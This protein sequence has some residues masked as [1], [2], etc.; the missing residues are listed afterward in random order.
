MTAPYARALPVAVVLVAALV[1]AWHDRGSIAAADFLPLELVVFL[2]LAVTLW[3]GV[4]VRPTGAAAAALGLFALLA[5]WAGASAL[6]APVPSLARDE[7]L[8]VLFGAAALA[9]PVLTLRTAADRLAALAVFVAGLVIVAGATALTLSGSSD[10][11]DVFRYRR[12]SFPIT[13]ANASAGLFLAGFWPA[14]MLAG[15]RSGRP[16]VRIA[17]FAAA[18]LLL[19]SSLLAQSK[20]GVVGLVAST[21]VLAA[22]SQARLR[23]LATALLAAVPAAL[24]FGPLTAA[25]T[26]T[27]DTELHDVHRAAGALLLVTVGSALLGAALAAADRRIDLSA[28]R[29][30]IGRV[31]LGAFAVTL[32]AALAVIALSHPTTWVSDHWR[33]FKKAPSPAAVSGTTHL[34]ELGSNRYDFWRVALGEFERHP[35]VGDGARGFGPAYLV[36]GRSSET[37]ARAHSLPLELLGEEGVVGFALAFAGYAV[38]LGGLAVRTRRRSAA[39]TAALGGCALLLAQACVDWTFTFPALT[40]PFFLLAG[41]GLAD[42]G[43]AV[44]APRARRAGWI[45]ALVLAA[46]LVA[47]PWL[48]AKLVQR[49]LTTRSAADLRWAHRLDPIS[50]DPWIAE[51]Q[52]ATSPDAAVAPLERAESRAP[53]SLAVRYLLGSVYWNAGRRADALREFEAALALHPHDAAVERALA[54]VRAR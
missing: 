37:P 51:A 32:A 20:G 49:G 27:G 43:R 10:L 18:S 52:T 9:V 31:V 13:Y 50:I 26:T 14:V 15:R 35:V 2:L 47:P 23:L 44:L 28:R 45:G 19:G 25:Y 17:A 6:W 42:D 12:L 53:R 30:L 38:L 36:H 24:A 39:A 21:L 16:P 40:V 34:V 48:S 1:V 29:R 3:A 46:V 41:I 54:V 11:S 7:A 33:T 4:A 22:V 8:L 5:V